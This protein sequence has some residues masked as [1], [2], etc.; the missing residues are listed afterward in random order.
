MT[1]PA[2]TPPAAFPA[3]VPG[4]LDAAGGQPLHPTAREA[5]LAA[6]AD[7]W[8]D[9]ARLHHAGRR[10]GLL[11]D[12][13]RA[14]LAASLGVRPD[15]VHLASSTAVATRAL[16]EGTLAAAPG[17][18]TASAIETSVVLDALTA[19]APGTT[20]L[21]VDGS[22]RLDLAV[23]Q[24]AGELRLLAVQVANAEVGT[25]QDLG[26]VAA[27]APGAALLADAG[28]CIGR[29]PLPAGWSML[30]ASARDWMGPA[31]VAIAVVRRSHRW[32]RPL[33]SERGWLAGFPDIPGAV[34]AATA[35][36]HVLPQ[37]D[38]EHDRARAMIDR[39]R[40]RLAAVPDIDLPGDPEQR[41]PHVLTAS[42][43]YVDGEA[44]VTELDR[45]GFAVA[46]GSACVADGERPSHV[47]A[48]MGALTGGNVRVSLPFGCDA[49][50][51]DAFAAAFAEAV[52]DLRGRYL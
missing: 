47:L 42:A 45:R 41:L 9:P 15:E 22:G 30:T 40:A 7:G 21:P 11:L 18:V 37:R 27:A 12:A 26:D 29:I 1:F 50:T 20:L 39:L 4:H 2:A 35:L 36:E 28:Q 8:A 24:R 31:G 51:V 32:V 19:V 5:W 34:A 14:S 23:L 6:V 33:G 46:S 10:A 17:P 52:V 16:V 44:L 49:I 3:A 48:A 43:L 38:T 25:T 13:A